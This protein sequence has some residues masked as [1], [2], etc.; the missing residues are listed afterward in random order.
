MP[1]WIKD[2]WAQA[3]A[4]ESPIEISGRVVTVCDAAKEFKRIVYTA[5]ADSFAEEIIRAPQLRQ[6]SQFAAFARHLALQTLAG[7]ERHE[8]PEMK[9]VNGGLIPITSEVNEGAD[10]FTW[11]EQFVTDEGNKLLANDGDDIPLVDVGHSLN[12]ERVHSF[13]R[14]YYYT[15]QD[16]RKSRFVGVTDL[17]QDKAVATREAMDRNLESLIT[18]GAPEASVHG[19]FEA[20]LVPKYTLSTGLW[21]AISPTGDDP[22]QQVHDEFRD[23]FTRVNVQSEG[24]EEPDTALLPHSTYIWLST[25]RNSTASDRTLLEWL[26]ASYPMITRWDWTRQ[27]TRTGAMLLYKNDPSRIRAELPMPPT[28]SEVEK[29]GR[30]YVT[31]M[32]GRYGSLVIKRPKSMVLVRNVAPAA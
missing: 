1:N 11:I 17:I 19:V 29:R 5:H 16:V 25:T 7:I 6:D 3:Y 32:E 13:G 30:R 22:Y 14:A 26:Q 23:A 27:N 31:E 12:F 8:Y 18:D 24:I 10:H 21:E 2:M 9:W 28:P 20:P 15:A 4:D